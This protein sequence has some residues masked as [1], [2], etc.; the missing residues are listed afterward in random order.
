A[1]S[2][3]RGL[4]SVQKIFQ[5]GADRLERGGPAS[6][7]APLGLLAGQK[8]SNLILQHLAHEHRSRCPTRMRLCWGA[9]IN[10]EQAFQPALVK[11]KQT[12]DLSLSTLR[13]CS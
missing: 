13:S 10:R 6:G 9:G 7:H 2:A 1:L 8:M 11:S 5:V 3:H 12:N 4:V